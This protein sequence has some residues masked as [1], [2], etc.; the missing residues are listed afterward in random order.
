MQRREPPWAAAC[1]TAR[2]RSTSTV[3]AGGASA[4]LGVADRD[5]RRS[6]FVQRPEPRHRLRG[7][8]R[9]GRCPARPSSVDQARSRARRQRHQRHRRQGPGAHLGVGSVPAGSRSA[10]SRSPR[11]KRCSEALANEAEVASRDRSASTRSAR[12]G[13]AA[14]PRRRCGRSSSSGPRRRLHRLAL[15]VA[16]GA[17]R[18]R[19]HV[20]RRVDQR[21]RLLGASTSRSRRRRSSRSSTIL[22]FSLYDTIVVFDKVKEN[23]ERFAGSARRTPT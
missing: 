20:A 10:T 13:V 23:A 6:L 18:H 9:R 19:R 5:H 12:R 7:R 11:V 4:A 17:G 3:A 22:G 14:S 2:P 1:T 15:R 8:R 16:H 21:R